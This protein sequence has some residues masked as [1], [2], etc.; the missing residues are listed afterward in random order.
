MISEVT[1][2]KDFGLEL[3]DHI[4]NA[5]WKPLLGADG[6]VEKL[7]ILATAWNPG[8]FAVMEVVK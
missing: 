7:Y 4:H 5:A 3:F 6:S 2:K 1:P 8:G